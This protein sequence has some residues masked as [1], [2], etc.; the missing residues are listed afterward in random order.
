ME[1]AL[2]RNNSRGRAGE[3]SS[4]PLAA[5][6]RTARCSLWPFV[7][8]SP[9]TLRSSCLLLEKKGP[10]PFIFAPTTL[11]PHPPQ[12]SQAQALL[13]LGQPWFPI[14]ELWRPSCA[15]TR[16]ETGKTDIAI[17]G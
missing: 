15:A 2:G 16:G 8:L 14:S 10:G 3:G 6:L 5:Q 17:L 9:V 13:V 12:Q 1:G 7:P 4:Q 11:M